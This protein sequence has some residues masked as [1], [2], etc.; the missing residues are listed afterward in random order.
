MTASVLLTMLRKGVSVTPATHVWCQGMSDWAC[1]RNVETFS[2]EASLQDTSWYYVDSDSGEQKGP[3]AIRCVSW[4]TLNSYAIFPI[5]LSCRLLRHMMKEG[6][7]DGLTVVYD[8]H[9]NKWVPLGEIPVLKAVMQQITAEEDIEKGCDI[10]D[11]EKVFEDAEDIPAIP[12]EMHQRKTKRSF[13]ADDGKHFVWDNEEN[14]WVEDENPSGSEDSDEEEAPNAGKKAHESVDTSE[15][16]AADT[17]AT[18]QKRKR[19]KKKK[20]GWK[21]NASGLWIYVTGLPSD[22]TAEELKSHFSKVSVCVVF[23]RLLLI[24]DIVLCISFRLD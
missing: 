6:N 16:Q 21:E 8:Q 13:Q 23:V 19:K 5:C 15:E 4:Q 14:E 24:A 18:G 9:V 22:V 7:I 1:M 17:Q 2:R 11:S 10:P 12:Q 3:I 20:S